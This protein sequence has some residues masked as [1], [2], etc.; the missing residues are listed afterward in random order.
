MSFIFR[1]ETNEWD[2]SQ[3]PSCPGCQARSEIATDAEVQCAKCLMWFQRVTAV[4]DDQPAHTSPYDTLPTARWRKALGL[5]IV[6]DNIREFKRVRLLSTTR[7]EEGE[8]PSLA[9][10]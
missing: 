3:R 9:E 6:E 5:T 4:E 10:L 8:N 7:L 2:S 1:A